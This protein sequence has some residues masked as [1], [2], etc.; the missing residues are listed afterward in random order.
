MK[1]LVIEPSLSSEVKSLIS[2]KKTSN[3]SEVVHPEQF[4]LPE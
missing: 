3:I 1:S 4:L 2:S